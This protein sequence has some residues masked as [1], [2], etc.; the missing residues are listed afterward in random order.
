MP[1]SYLMTWESGTR[2][3]RIKH[4]NK[5]YTI[6][7][8]ALGVPPTKEQSYQAANAWWTAKRA[9]IEAGSPPPRPHADALAEIARRLAWR[10]GMARATWRPASRR[11]LRC[12]KAT[13]TVTS[14][15]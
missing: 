3:W 1:R 12:S 6:S 7:C 5:V 10:K 15:G 4:R 2:R 14:G 8:R 11:T 9:E 13:G